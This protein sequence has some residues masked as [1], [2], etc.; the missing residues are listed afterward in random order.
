MRELFRRRTRGGGF[1]SFA[2]FL[3]LAPITRELCRASKA[4]MMRRTRVCKTLVGADVSTYTSS[5]CAHTQRSRLVHYLRLSSG[6]V[7]GERRGEEGGRHEQPEA[8]PTAAVRIDRPKA[9]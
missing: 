2:P 1:L 7:E 4:K 9:V 6:A 8:S 3:P 5:R